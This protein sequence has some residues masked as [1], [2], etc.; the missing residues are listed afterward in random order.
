MAAPATRRGPR[1]EPGGEAGCAFAQ[2]DGRGTP[3]RGPAAPLVAG[4]GAGCDR[5]ARPGCRMQSGRAPEGT[6][7]WHGPLSS[8]PLAFALVLPH[9]AWGV[10]GCGGETRRCRVRRKEGAG[11]PRVWRMPTQD[12][13]ETRAMGRTAGE[14]GWDRGAA[15]GTQV[16]LGALARCVDGAP[17]PDL[18][19]SP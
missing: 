12:G 17:C 9:R 13:T 7:T 16:L 14:P 6:E 19:S 5:L 10:R 18:L 1:S 4:R 3:E 8:V 11:A 15:L 2:A